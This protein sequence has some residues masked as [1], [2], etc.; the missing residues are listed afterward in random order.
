[1]NI[2]QRSGHVF[3]GKVTLGANGD[4]YYEYLLKQVRAHT[5]VI[6]SFAAAYSKRAEQV[7]A[8]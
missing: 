3:R 8:Y 4:S 6:F 1:M 2:H 7:K 5:L